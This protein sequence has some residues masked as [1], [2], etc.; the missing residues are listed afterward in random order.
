MSTERVDQSAGRKQGGV[1][2]KEP[3]KQSMVGNLRL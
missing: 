2:N 3:S 1:E